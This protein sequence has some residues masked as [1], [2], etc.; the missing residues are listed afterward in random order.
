MDFK[1]KPHLSLKH[2][3]GYIER[4]K[5]TEHIYIYA[6]IYTHLEIYREKKR[7]REID[8]YANHTDRARARPGPCRGFAA[9]ASMAIARYSGYYHLK[10]IYRKVC[11]LICTLDNKTCLVLF[12][13]NDLPIAFPASW[14]Y[15][16][17]TAAKFYS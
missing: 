17:A 15:L 9:A 12:F 11:L 1:P 2:K 7:E 5:Q 8:I 4:D 10:K 16:A 3:E 13:K 6:H 14:T